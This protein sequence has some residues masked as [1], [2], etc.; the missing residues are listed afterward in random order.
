MISYISSYENEKYINLTIEEIQEN[1]VMAIINE[2]FDLS[3]YIKKQSGQ[4]NVLKALIVDVDAIKDSQEEFIQALSNFRML[5]DTKIIV[6]ATGR[7]PG[8]TILN[9]VFCTG[10]YD[11]ITAEKEALSEELKYCLEKGKNFQDSARFQILENKENETSEASVIHEKLIIKKSVKKVA[12]KEIIGFMGTQS[13]VGV[14]H[15]CI[16]CAEYLKE[17]SFKVA[18]V[19]LTN[20]KSSYEKIMEYYDYGLEDDEFFNMDGIAVYP[21]Y[22]MN[23]LHLIMAQNYHFILIDFGIYRKEIETE[24]IRTAVPIVVACSKPWEVDQMNNVFSA[25]NVD[26]LKEFYYLFSFTIDEEKIELEANMGPLKNIYYQNYIENPF[27]G[28]DPGILKEILKGYMP[29]ESITEKKESIVDKIKWVFE[30]N[31]TKKEKIE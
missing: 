31:S 10:I 1:V 23:K 24:F 22:D 15:N 3:D 16:V 28:K 20:E 29:E 7:E 8:D 17:N 12:N 13:R 30:K 27:N 26:I 2:E 19:E 6:I 21:K 11:I 18:I 4:I 25:I 5:Y 9:G 14:T